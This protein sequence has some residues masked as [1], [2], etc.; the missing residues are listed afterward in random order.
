MNKYLLPENYMLTSLI[1][2]FR[3]V[4]TQIA[5]AFFMRRSDEKDKDKDASRSL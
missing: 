3:I 1:R 5:V 4:L 2:F